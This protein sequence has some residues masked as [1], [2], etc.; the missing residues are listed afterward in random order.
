MT[1]VADAC[2]RARPNFVA[3]GAPG[4]PLVE[5][6]DAASRLAGA[7]PVDAF[8]APRL[9][10][11]LVAEGHDPAVVGDVVSFLAGAQRAP[12]R[13]SVRLAD[14]LDRYEASA[15]ALTAPGTQATYRTW[16][17]RLRSAHG[18]AD[19]A[20]LGIAELMDVIAVHATAPT[21]GRTSR[22]RAAE[23]N[24][25]GAYRHLWRYMV[26]AGVVPRNIAMELRKP[27]RG[28]PH[29]RPIKPD[30]A[31]L[32]S[33]LA[34]TGREPE[35]DC[36]IVTLAERLG[37]RRIE[38]CRLRVCD[39]D[40]DERTVLV[41]GKQDK[42]RELPLPPLLAAQLEDYLEGR[43]PAEVPTGEWRASRH[44]LLM[45]KPTDARHPGLSVERRRIEALFARLRN[46]AP[47]LFR[48]GG[49]SLHSYRHALA[50]FVDGRYGRAVTRAVLGHT[51]RHSPTDVYVHVSMEDKRVA[52]DAYEGHVHGAGA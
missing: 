10:L 14:V 36:L 50:T 6:V 40:L 25:V 46:D 34:A 47:E 23:E 8:G 16:V 5:V 32:L 26:A 51:S 20:A 38:I 15:L 52:I 22:S 48:R 21:R 17:K 45:R 3:L 19:P 1:T 7:Q 37:L 30:E 9:A 41:F 29:R 11:A 27:A 42:A 28:E 24:A 49:V 33:A 12:A 39:V 31:R 18:D 2:A 4:A 13:P 44:P 43:R 35:L